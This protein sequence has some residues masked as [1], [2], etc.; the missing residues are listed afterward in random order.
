MLLLKTLAPWLLLAF[1]GQ[2]VSVS[3][4]ARNKTRGA[5][6]T[7]PIPGRAQRSESKG[8]ATG[9]GKFSLKDKM[10]CT[11]AARNAGDSVKLLVKCENP[12]AR[13]KGGVT[14]MQCEYN[15]KPQTCP[16]YR[17]D[18]KG[19]WKQVSRAF[20][21]LQGKVCRDDRALLKAGMCKRVPFKL[22]ISTSSLSAQ[23]GDPETP[24]PRP[25]TT[26]PG[27]TACTK[28]ADHLKTAE[29]YCSSSWA[30]VCSFFFSMLQSE[31][32]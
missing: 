27:P 18:P 24:P 6:K 3:S 14:D 1:L 5:N 8:T 4:G 12:E 20:K 16:G 23:S 32:C 21:R 31:D 11:W 9:R 17:S 22:N 2:Q 7:V 30:S 29:E 13:V 28:R 15:A 26:S 19:F 10:Q 25:R